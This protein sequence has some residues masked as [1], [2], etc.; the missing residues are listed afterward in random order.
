MRFPTISPVP[1]HNIPSSHPLTVRGSRLR[2]WGMHDLLH[3]APHS[4]R[5]TCSLVTHA[6]PV[7]AQGS[8][9]EVCKILYRRAGGERL[10]PFICTVLWPVGVEYI[11]FC[12]GGRLPQQPAASS[13]RP[14]PKD[15]GKVSASTS[16]S[17][18][19]KQYE[20]LQGTTKV[21][22]GAT[23]FSFLAS[24]PPTLKLTNWRRLRPARDTTL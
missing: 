13:R 17:S 15:R 11:H 1:Y 5:P 2:G 3:L 4:L 9:E 23:G 10:A 18:S 19:P 8:E 16:Q 14:S 20:R 21:A 6:W 12:P 22:G 7:V 24:C